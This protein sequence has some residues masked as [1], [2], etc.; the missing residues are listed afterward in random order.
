MKRAEREERLREMRRLYW[1][2]RMTL[3]EV[4]ARSG[5]SRQRVKQI[6]D[7]A[8][9]PTRTASDAADLSSSRSET[10]AQIL[11]SPVESKPVIS[12]RA[13]SQRDRGWANRQEGSHLSKTRGGVVRW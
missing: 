11:G 3:E 6:F 8:Q 1:D 2:E 9:V 4:G 13:P 10:A 7:E 5:L 12:G